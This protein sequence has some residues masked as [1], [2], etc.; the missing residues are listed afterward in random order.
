MPSTRGTSDHGSGRRPG[1]RAGRR[2][3]RRAGRLPGCPPSTGSSLTL[4]S[5]SLGCPTGHSAWMPGRLP[6]RPERTTASYSSRVGGPNVCRRAGPGSQHRPAP[7][8]EHRRILRRGRRRLGMKPWSQ[9]DFDA[10]DPGSGARVGL[11]GWAPDV[12]GPAMPIAGPRLVDRSSR[13]NDIR[14]IPT[15]HE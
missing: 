14:A 6:S 1:R 7:K 3:G 5:P 15:S 13:T 10:A 4:T 11:A 8:K 2:S 12:S 9:E